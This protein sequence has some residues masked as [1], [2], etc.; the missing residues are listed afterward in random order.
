MNEHKSS[1][2]PKIA[3]ILL[4]AILGVVLFFALRPKHP[5]SSTSSD[6]RF[7]D[8]KVVVSGDAG[9]AFRYWLNREGVS[10]F[11]DRQ[12]P[13][14]IEI[15]GGVRSVEIRHTDA[16]G[17]LELKVQNQ[18]GESA[19]TSLTKSNEYADLIITETAVLWSLDHKTVSQLKR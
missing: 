6:S 5:A 16:A 8:R 4:L 15:S 19:M 9:T 7:W 2:V 11:G 18:N 1:L 13:A 10:E 12:A 17:T 14:M 3:G